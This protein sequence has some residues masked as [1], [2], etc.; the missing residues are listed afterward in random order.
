MYDE[1]FAKANELMQKGEPFATATVVRAEKPTSGKPGDKAIISRG[2][3][4]YG[5]IGGSCAQPTVVREALAAIAEDKGRLVRLTPG[6]ASLEPREGVKE[7]PMTCFSG[8]T[9]DIYIEPQQPRPRLIIVGDLPVARA[10]AHLGKAMSYHVI[11]VD[12][13][14]GTEQGEGA[15]SH[16]DEVLNSLE[17]I[18]EK[19]NP[20]TFVVVAT[21]GHYDEKALAAALLTPA[22][23]VALVGSRKRSEAVLADLRSRG[24]EDEEMTRL[25]V[26][27]G[28]DIQAR[29]GDE[30]ALSIMAEIVQVRRRAEGL[31]WSLEDDASGDGASEDHGATPEA[32]GQ[33][34]A[35]CCAAAET[36]EVA[37][38]LP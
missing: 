9:L 38:A 13:G 35:C 31:A 33:E 25:K 17:G 10:L 20:L 3:V 2:G 24:F 1:F 23:Y 30:I 11:A 21:H 19:A 8:G 7:L 16:A 22:P 4:M 27:A 34:A 26:P 37:R 5:W 14:P 36:D 6:P 28:L 12:L 29:R 32:A 15:M 18:P